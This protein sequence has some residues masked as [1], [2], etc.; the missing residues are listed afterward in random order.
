M[1]RFGGGFRTALSFLYSICGRPSKSV[2]PPVTI[3]F[4]MIALRLSTEQAEQHTDIHAHNRVN[5]P[6]GPIQHTTT[7]R[8]VYLNPKRLSWDVA[9]QQVEV[10]KSGRQGAPITASK[11]FC[12]TLSSIA[13]EFDINRSSS[14]HSS[15]SG[16]KK[17]FSAIRCEKLISL[18]SSW[19]SFLPSGSVKDVCVRQTTNRL[20]QYQG[21]KCKTI[22]V[23]VQRRRVR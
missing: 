5:T 7:P 16:S 12:C 4:A 20:S 21:M 8:L 19:T 10:R 6:P 13:A 14:S 22:M 1:V 23:V 2:L 15:F 9:G 18:S 11:I 17:N 3:T